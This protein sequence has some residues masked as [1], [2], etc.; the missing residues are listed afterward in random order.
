MDLGLLT[1][2]GHQ[3][4]WTQLHPDQVIAIKGMVVSAKDVQPSSLRLDAG[5]MS[6]RVFVERTHFLSSKSELSKWLA[7]KRHRD[8]AQRSAD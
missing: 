8:R 5:P 6:V 1:E 3:R 7:N 4:S 2:G